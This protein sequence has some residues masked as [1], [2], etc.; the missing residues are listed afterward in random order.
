MCLR[1]RSPVV[2][3]TALW[4]VLA[5]VACSNSPF[6]D[7]GD[8]TSAEIVGGDTTLFAGESAQ[9]TVVAVYPIGSGAPRSVAWSV[10][11]T[12]RLGLA[13]LPDWSAI[14]TARDT[15]PATVYG[16][17]N[18]EFH[19]SV[20][21]TIVARGGVRWRRALAA[22]P[23]LYAALDSAQVYATTTDNQLVVV[24]A[25]DGAPVRGTALCAGALGPSIG[26][27]GVT[28][29]GQDCVARITRTGGPVWSEAFGQAESGAAIGLDDASLVVSAEGS[30]GSAAVVLSRISALG[31]IVWRD[32]LVTALQ[33]TGAALAIGSGGSI[34][35][36]WR[37]ATD[38][39]RLSEFTSAGAPAW[40]LE[41]P[42]RVRLASPAVAGT[43]VVVTY[44]GGVLAA[45]TTGDTVW[46]RAFADASPAFSSTEAASSPTVDGSGNI[47]VQTPH[48]LLSYT[49]A[50]VVRWVADSL[51]GGDATLGVG[52]PTFLRDA[53][54]VVPCG[55]DVCGVASATGARVWR[56]AL[57]G[58]IGGATVGPDGTIIVP[59]RV[60]GAGELVGLWNRSG[61]HVSGWP[62]EGFDAARSRR[63]H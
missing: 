32:T 36:P 34:Y 45:L 54:L 12:T 6:G 35:V 46:S 31:A 9:Y 30:G 42:G 25:V 50:G 40:T 27:G 21:F 8:A 39:S 41:L 4:V 57:G 38:S 44:D 13:A 53:T 10:S 2:A 19:D 5:I 1:H 49:N 17:I 61:L 56:T 43:R 63:V 47:Y 51:G 28:S 20:R 60:G 15:G 59:R 37:T 26:G 33:P 16:F 18:E 24:S 11:D 7:V 22:N 62:T 29:I 55:G 48:G 3:A 52:A 23:T 58:V 14:V